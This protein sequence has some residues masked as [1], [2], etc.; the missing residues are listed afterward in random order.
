M[1]LPVWLYATVPIHESSHEARLAVKIL[2]KSSA[3]KKTLKNTSYAETQM[4]TDIKVLQ[5]LIY[6]SHFISS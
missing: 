1:A 3:S 5:H 4:Q 6:N 2:A